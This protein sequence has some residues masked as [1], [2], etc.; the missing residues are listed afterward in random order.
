MW[1][2]ERNKEVMKKWDEDSFAATGWIEG[3]TT[4]L[5]PEDKPKGPVLREKTTDIQN[6]TKEEPFPQPQSETN[7]QQSPGQG[8]AMSEQD[9]Q[10]STVTTDPEAQ[11]HH[12]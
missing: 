12:V 9:S 10:S 3:D 5:F 6:G 4:V 8:V 11:G 7:G 1:M 2:V